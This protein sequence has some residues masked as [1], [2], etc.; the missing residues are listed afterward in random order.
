M[1]VYNSDKIV[2]SLHA[3]TYS[4]FTI[5]EHQQIFVPGII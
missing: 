3:M 1:C 2:S 5:W 4:M